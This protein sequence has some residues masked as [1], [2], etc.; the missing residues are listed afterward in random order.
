MNLQ[1]SREGTAFSY[2][3]PSE[4]KAMSVAAGLPKTWCN[5][6]VAAVERAA[7]LSSLWVRFPPRSFSAAVYTL[8]G[9]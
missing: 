6:D 7:R 5:I 4:L 1:V 3:E 9:A 8:L 2:R